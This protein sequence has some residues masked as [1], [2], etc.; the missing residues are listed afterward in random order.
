MHRCRILFYQSPG[1]ID[2]AQLRT[3]PWHYDCHDNMAT[4]AAELNKT[5]VKK[6]AGWFELHCEG[7]PEPAPLPATTP[8]VVAQQ[9][10]V[11][12]EN[13]LRSAHFVET[14]RKREE[15]LATLVGHSAWVATTLECFVKEAK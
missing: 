3:L 12:L 14:D 2:E 4:I 10:A 11:D 6:A 1:G 9:K 13:A 8:I 15:T 5:S 7:Q